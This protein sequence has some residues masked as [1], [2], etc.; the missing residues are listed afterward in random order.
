M[1]PIQI[2]CK[3]NQWHCNGAVILKLHYA[4][5]PKADFNCYPSTINSPFITSSSSFSSSS[6]SLYSSSFPPSPTSF[7]S[8]SGPC[9]YRSY[10]ADKRRCSL[11]QNQKTWPVV[12]Y[13]C[14]FLPFNSI[15]SDPRT[16]WRTDKASFRVR[17]SRLKRERV[18]KIYLKAVWS[19]QRHWKTNLSGRKSC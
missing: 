4:N 16:V 2:D 7:P 5:Y 6:S 1:L 12:S 11:P 9:R 17:S 15:I 8:S 10:S 18:V 13:L 3:S 19:Q 14:V